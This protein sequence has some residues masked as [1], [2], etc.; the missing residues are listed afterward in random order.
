MGA[1]TSGQNDAVVPVHQEPRH[2]MVFDSPGTRILDVQIPP[3]DTTLFHTHNDPILYV[4][5]SGSTMR[6]QTLG[7]EWNGTPA[8][9]PP[10]AAPFKIAPS[11]P[12][13]RMMSTTTYAER[14]VTHRVSNV[15]ETLYRLIA[16]TNASAGDES[17][18]P[19]PGFDGTPEIANRWFRGY[20][21]LV[22]ADAGS[23]HRHANP[24]NLVLV[25]GRASATIGAAKKALDQVGQ[26]AF[27]EPNIPHRL[28]SVG[29]E[30][31][32]VEVEVRRPARR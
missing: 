18:A 15:G 23:E 30:A 12:P 13:G 4:N 19:S 27:I 31:Q 26:F 25:S 22:G 16:T 8:A 32:L 17:T 6:N 7:G 5:M 24:V 9:G 28:E 21:V 20:R 3:G 2:R 29:G 1:A 11:S 14:P 10:A